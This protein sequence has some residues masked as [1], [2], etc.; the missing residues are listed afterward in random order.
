QS[1]DAPGAPE[2]HQDEAA[3]GTQQDVVWFDIAVNQRRR[4]IVQVRQDLQHPPGDG[5]QLGLRQRSAFNARR[6]RLALD[7]LGGQIQAEAH[8]AALRETANEAGNR[9]MIQR[10]QSRGFAFESVDLRGVGA[11]GELKLF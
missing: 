6:E 8:A 3:V 1:D 9:W 4:S 7:E 11:G 2:V 10:L 5:E